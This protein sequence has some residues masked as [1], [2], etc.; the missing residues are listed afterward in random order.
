M[1]QSTPGVGEILSHFSLDLPWLLLIVA[2]GVWYAVAARRA[3]GQ[4]RIHQHP[5]WKVATFL[6]G[7]AILAVG[8]MSPIEYYGNK[9]LWVD[10]L[11]FLLVTMMAAPLLVLSSPLTLAFRVSGPTAR[12]R[13][14]RCYRSTPVRLVTFPVASGLI[15]ATVTYLWQFSALTDIAARHT[16][17]REVQ[18]FSLFVVALVFWTPALCADPVRWRTAY[19][20]RG[21]Y[22]FVE[23][24]H[25]ALFGAMFLALNRPVHTEM[26]SRLPTYGP[27]A[28]TDQR[29]A[30][31][32]LWIGGNLIFLLTLVGIIKRWVEY[33][34]R[35]T[36]RLDRRLAK[37]RQAARAKQA[38]LDKVFERGI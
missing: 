37:E 2:A 13:L 12:R 9:L 10:F 8:V 28:L 3:F 20:L 34:A 4:P 30:I 24:T 19:P 29:L 25:K 32:I 21:L 15:F 26:A 38:A 17:V 14:R 22:V 11:G 6:G 35:N 33:E 36:H 23:T 5:R 7:L 18:E 1:Q 31:V 16:A 27:D